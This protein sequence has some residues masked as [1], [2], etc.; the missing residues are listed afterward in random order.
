MITET[1]NIVNGLNLSKIQAMRDAVRK[2]PQ[3]ARSK[4]QTKTTRRT[5]YYNEVAT[6]EFWLG[7]DQKSR[8]KLFLILGD[9]PLELLGTKKERFR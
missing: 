6:K 4:F 8:A 9:H 7:G 3:S 1:A 5:G 2:H